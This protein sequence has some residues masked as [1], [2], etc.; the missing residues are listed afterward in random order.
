MNRVREHIP[1]FIE[2]DSGP[3]TVEFETVEE[4]LSI[5]WIKY[6]EAPIGRRRFYQWAKCG[7]C[8]MAEYSKGRFWLVIGYLERPDEVDLPEVIYE[9]VFTET[10]IKSRRR[11]VR[12]TA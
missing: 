4:L 6:F 2:S 10:E 5:P 1:N 12:S 8:L 11:V 3:V 7:D 9:S